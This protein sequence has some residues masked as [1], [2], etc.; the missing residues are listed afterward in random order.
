MTIVDEEE[1]PEDMNT[2]AAVLYGIGEKDKAM[3]MYARC[4]L[5]YQRECHNKELRETWETMKEKFRDNVSFSI[6]IHEMEE[7]WGLVQ[8]NK[9]Q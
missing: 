1:Y 7:Y 5:A 4:M 9:Q 3:K 6:S 2:Y 8:A